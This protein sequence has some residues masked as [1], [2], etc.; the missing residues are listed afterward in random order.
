MRRLRRSRG[1]TAGG[2][3]DDDEYEDV[4]GGD[5]IIGWMNEWIG[6]LVEQERAKEQMMQIFPGRFGT[7]LTCLVTCRIFPRYGCSIA[8]I[9]SGVCSQ[10]PL[11]TLVDLLVDFFLAC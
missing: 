7:N 11:S 4:D 5:N 8:F 1:S 9:R 2:G 6:V 10:Q 3:D